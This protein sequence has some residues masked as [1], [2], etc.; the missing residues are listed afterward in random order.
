MERPISLLYFEFYTRHVHATEVAP[1]YEL[2]LVRVLFLFRITPFC[3]HYLPY[4]FVLPSCN[5]P[6]CILAVRKNAKHC[7]NAEKC[8]HKESDLQHRKNYRAWYETSE[9]FLC[10]RMIH[11]VT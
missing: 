10:R 3:V 5:F 1:S 7:P 2:V 11:V 9:V 6:G 4:L 8:C